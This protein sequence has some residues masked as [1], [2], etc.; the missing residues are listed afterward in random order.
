MKHQ[1]KRAAIKYLAEG[2]PIPADLYIHLNNAGIDPEALEES[3]NER[4]A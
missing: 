1:L 4:R 2:E 3:Y